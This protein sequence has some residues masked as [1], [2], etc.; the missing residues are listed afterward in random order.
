MFV[1]H[2]LDE[3]GV[4]LGTSVPFPDQASAEEWMG[5]AWADLRERGV[6][7]VALTDEDRGRRIYRM[8]LAEEPA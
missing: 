6:E 2:Y 4:E 7:E 3:T 1:W 8:G 5:D